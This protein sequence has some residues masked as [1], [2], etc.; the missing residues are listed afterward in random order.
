MQTPKRI[1]NTSLALL[2]LVV[3]AAFWLT[4][5][6]NGTSKTVQAGNDMT[7]I[8]LALELFYS[9]AGRFPTQSEGLDVL[10]TA[11]AKGPHLGDD[12][13]IDPW[14]RPYLYTFASGSPIPLVTT[15]GADGTIG[16]TGE[17]ADLYARPIL[18]SSFQTP[19]SSVTQSPA[20]TPNNA[21]PGR[22]P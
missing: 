10:Y 1:L 20:T 9:H 7:V 19:P 2:V 18:S 5:R 6:G 12:V 4:L 13:R 21:P 3:A 14:G 17:N 8:R 11:T 22:T 16:G 15:L